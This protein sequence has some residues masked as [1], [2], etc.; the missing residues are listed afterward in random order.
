MTLTR[1]PPAA[2]VL[3]LPRLDRWQPMRA[4]IVNIWHY[5]PAQEFRFD[6]GRMVLHGRNGAGK[7]KALE[8][9]YPLLL[10][11][12]LDAGR[13]APSGAEMRT[14]IHNLLEPDRDGTFRRP[15]R[16]GFVWLEFGRRGPDD[17]PLFLTL[18]A[19]LAATASTRKV[20]GHFFHTSQRVG[21]A[22]LL[23]DP[24]PDGT[25]HVPISRA[26]L[27]QRIGDAGAVFEQRGAYRR[28]VDERLFGLGRRYEGLVNLL[29]RMRRPHL[30]EKLDLATVRSYL[31]E[32]L[33][34]LAPE[35]ID[36]PIDAFEGLHRDREEIAALERALAGI[37][38]VAAAHRTYATRE[39]GARADRLRRAESAL[40]RARE[41]SRLAAADAEGKAQKRSDAAGRVIRLEAREISLR[42]V[43]AVLLASPE[44]QA[45]GRLE[46]AARAAS[47][48]K[49]RASDDGARAGDAEQ[50]A[51]DL[52]LIERA[53]ATALPGVEGTR[54]R[55]V[56]ALG[57]AA[58]A[59][60]M[61]AAQ[62]RFV[63]DLDADPDAA[64]IPL[65]GGIAR[66][67]EVLERLDQTVSKRNSVADGLVRDRKNV[68]TAKGRADQATSSREGASRE[69]D[70]SIERLH[71]SLVEW[72]GRAPI[73]ALDDEAPDALVARVAA[74]E[75]LA[76]EIAALAV[77]PRSALVEESTRL[78]EAGKGLRRTR[79]ALVAE[80]DLVASAT[81]MRPDEHSARPAAGRANREG[82][83]LYELVDFAPD[84]SPQERAGLEAALEGSALLD[85]WVTPAGEL[86]GPM[87]LDA[88]IGSGSPTKGP[89]L[90]G[91]LTAVNGAAPEAIV[92]AILRSIPLGHASGSSGTW[93]DL[94][95]R[96]RIGPLAG[97]HQKARSEYVG[98]GA[99][100]ATRAARIRELDERVGT[101][102][103]EIETNRLALA[104]VAARQRA[105][106]AEVTAA[107]SDAA[108]ATTRANLARKTT[109][110]SERHDEH[111][112]RARDL[113]TREQTLARLETDLATALSSAGIEG[114]PAA[115][116]GA[117]GALATFGIAAS[118]ARRTTDALIRARADVSRTAGEAATAR[119][120]AV[121]ERDRANVSAAETRRLELELRELEG[122]VGADARA[123]VA[124][125][126]KLDHTIKLVVT[127]LRA[128]RDASGA[129]ATA[130]ALAT[131][132][133][134]SLVETEE[135][136]LS[137]RDGHATSFRAVAV[138]GLLALAL[139]DPALGDPADWS[140]REAVE[141]ARRIDTANEAAFRSEA[142]NAA[143][144]TL[145]DRV[146]DLDRSIVTDYRIEIGIEPIEGF[147][148]PMAE[149]GEARM[150]VVALAATIRAD[151][152]D[153]TAL[154]SEK[155][156]AAVT[157]YFL[158]GVAVDLGERIRQA[159]ELV[160]GINAELAR[161]PT[162]SGHLIRL[163]WAIASAGAPPG[164]D[165]A[166]A[167]LM[168]R[169][170]DLNPTDTDTLVAFFNGQ[171]EAARVSELAFRE[172]LSAAL[173]YRTWHEFTIFEGDGRRW[174]PLNKR[175]H[176]AGSGGEQSVSLHLPLF[177]AASA[178][179]SSARVRHA[180]RLI[181]LDEAFAGIDR[182]M[183]GSIM[184]VMREFDFDF[185]LTSPDEWGDYAA[186][187]GCA[188]YLLA[189]DVDGGRRGVVARH[190]TWTGRDLALDTSPSIAGL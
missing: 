50:R 142:I 37:E 122:L 112:R 35:Q 117:H 5:E 173:D 81:T 87:V 93:L 160:E 176:Q 86:L 161:R 118:E 82:A 76:H 11:A 132:L 49:V 66:R 6:H 189:R 172:A 10:D 13:L 136:I 94:D 186:L 64:W 91:V 116:A 53:A 107:P 151:V 156:R 145:Q 34:P 21:E 170:G 27:E 150:S 183:R 162:A 175:T 139:D 180:P 121:Q 60:A 1:L 42:D 63:E 184:G 46:D 133:H 181:A 16:V 143:K 39:A 58:V 105:L 144:T 157:G 7:T 62:A 159:H 138:H 71:A 97:R 96:F 141:I 47:G 100:E 59:A 126:T 36:P 9:L 154:A 67:R 55:A 18:G 119:T 113:A 95:G 99:R 109:E 135:R 84:L 174:W 83:P 163:R 120:L 102:D 51:G 44:M 41:A 178:Y 125:R 56:A 103:G 158:K 52:A 185:I 153:R 166:A 54:E 123:V 45:A 127:T 104:A 29:V 114:G 147:Y 57:T 124:R 15:S 108:V 78:T 182:E 23:A 167:L 38:L 68:E 90:A 179:F 88:A 85:A 98:A 131:S 89:S 48:A 152:E 33:P 8:L 134:G 169:P 22:L 72:V 14:M 168:L 146:R 69:V 61:T 12:D 130:A 20:S 129:A 110:E 80:R 2:V 24:A 188:S 171:V 28:A 70:R 128:A 155:L 25:S 140:T 3:P 148:L 165:R 177:A 43:L 73:L 164:A 26:A 75:H 187:D 115:L 74:G 101:L 92:T 4:G 149:L 106:D 40:G 137:E 111:K 31:T 32:A 77:E 79:E 65:S 17:A 190:W 19:R 30:S